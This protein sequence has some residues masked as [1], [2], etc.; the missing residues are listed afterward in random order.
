MR[1]KWV[2]FFWGGMDVF[3]IIRF[4]YLNIEKGRIPL[5]SDIIDFGNLTEIHTF[6]T[7]I[8]FAI[9][10]LLTLSIFFSAYFL[11]R[12]KGLVN[13]IVYAQTPFR[14]FFAIPSLSFLPWLIKAV[15]IKSIL[16]SGVILIASEIIKIVSL[17]V[18]RNS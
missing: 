5:I 3:Y 12:Q 14:L 6:Y 9:S 7:V 2:C 17:N 1:Y 11:I 10:L 18:S 16:I 15:D 13:Y 8:T 4:I